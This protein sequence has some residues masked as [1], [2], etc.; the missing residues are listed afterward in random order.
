MRLIKTLVILLVFA[1]SSFTSLSASHEPLPE[2]FLSRI[3]DWPIEHRL[4]SILKMIEK[5]ERGEVPA[6]DDTLHDLSIHLAIELSGVKNRAN[7]ILK[8]TEESIVSYKECIYASS[9]ADD[10]KRYLQVIANCEKSVKLIKADIDY[11]EYLQNKYFPQLSL[12]D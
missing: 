10:I 6:P 3:D 4:T 12:D 5:C 8:N 11:I 1:F 7:R 9:S 2:G